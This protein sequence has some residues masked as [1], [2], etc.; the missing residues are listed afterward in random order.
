MKNL[1]RKIIKEE[2]SMSS[3]LKQVILK[4]GWRIASTMIGFEKM[5]EIAF[6]KDYNEFL[7]LFSNMTKEY[8]SEYE[9]DIY[10]LEGSYCPFHFYR[11]DEEIMISKDKIWSF[12]TDGLGLSS[13]ETRKIIKEW[14]KETYN[15]T[16]KSH[17]PFH[18]YTSITSDEYK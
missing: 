15:V 8:N 3:K 6:N 9:R 18:P 11:P 10:C 16:S 12:F 2:T 13:D 14:L 4:K 7:E 17:R 1:I 5:F